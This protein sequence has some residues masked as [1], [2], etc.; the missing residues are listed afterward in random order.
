ML[1]TLHTKQFLKSDLNT[2]WDF[3]SSPENLARITPDYM[4]FDIISDKESI[5]KMYPGQLIEY[6]VSPILGIKM[7]WVTEITHVQDH[8]YFVDEQRFGPYALWHHKHF[9][10]EVNGG[11]E[12]TDILHYKVPF[13][14]IGKI[15]NYFFIKNK[16]NEI[17]DFRYHKLEE[18]FNNGK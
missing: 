16:I 17:F 1:H 8:C 6:Y 4:G 5:Q 9:L 13:G 3:M 2:V 18:I 12:M 14:F 11:V 15:V 10:K 7:H